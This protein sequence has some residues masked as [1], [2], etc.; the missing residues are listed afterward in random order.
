MVICIHYIHLSLLVLLYDR[1][2]R[3]YHVDKICIVNIVIATHK[4][5]MYTV[6]Y[7]KN[8]NKYYCIF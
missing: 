6:N 7:L 1:K 5:R 8:L 4:N 2:I 3:N